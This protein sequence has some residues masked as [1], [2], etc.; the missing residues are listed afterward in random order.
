MDKGDLTPVNAA[1]GQGKPKA[2][3]CAANWNK[4]KKRE[5]KYSIYWDQIALETEARISPL[6]IE[7]K[8]LYN[9]LV[10]AKGNIKVFCRIRPLFEDEGS[11]VVEF[12]DDFTIRINTGDDS[13]SNPKKDFEFDRVYG[14]HVG[15]GE[16]FHDV[17]PFVQ[18]AL[19]GYNVSV[20]A[21][22]Q[23]HSGKT[24]TMWVSPIK[25]LA[26]STAANGGFVAVDNEDFDANF[27]K[28]L[29]NGFVGRFTR[30]QEEL[31]IKVLIGK[32][33]GLRD[34]KNQVAGFIDEIVRGREVKSRSPHVQLKPRPN[35]VLKPPDTSLCPRGKHPLSLKS[36][37]GPNCVKTLRPDSLPGLSSMMIVIEDCRGEKP[38]KSPKMDSPEPSSQPVKKEGMVGE[39]KQKNSNQKPS[40]KPAKRQSTTKKRRKKLFIL[41]SKRGEGDLVQPGPPYLLNTPPN[42]CTTHIGPSIY[43]PAPALGIEV[44]SQMEQNNA[45]PAEGSSHERGLYVRCFEEL[46]DLSNSDSTS[47]SRFNFYVTVFDLYNEQVR[48]LLSESQNNLPK[49]L[50]GPPDSFAELVREKVENP[51]DF[52]KVLKVALQTRGTDVLKFNVSHLVITIHIHY[53]NWISRENLHSKLSL[54]DLAGSEGLLVENASGEHVTDMLHVMKSLSTLGDVLSSL[55]SKKELVP[56]GNSS[57]TT[58][59]ADSLGGSSKTLM[60]VNVFPNVSELPATLSA[61]NFSARARNV[62]LSLGNRDTIKKWRDVANDARKELYESEK[63][64]HD[65]KQESLG[66]KQTL[67]EAN[68][69]CVLLFN[70]VQKAWKVS[71]TLQAD[72]KVL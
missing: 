62:G 31:Q 13:I 42:S 52:S 66:M 38:E 24:H 34:Q 63:E 45:S 71:F 21:Y 44:L 41:K 1:V 6:I 15:Q 43:P 23:T 55:T 50:V 3:G 11:S 65:L 57:L 27:G 69:Q 4:G 67:K 58:M 14:P 5:R 2:F 17:Q 68:D 48:D 36:D 59:L 25:A 33:V 70:E 29:H 30:V 47:T 35:H 39:T 19:D 51:L 61:L 54:I 18:S 28:F 7:K 56:Y 49:V 8:R 10:T 40:S 60:V 72:L 26:S 37:P 20:F 12:P 22:G 64:I 16:L 32:S 46:F 9:D 53:T